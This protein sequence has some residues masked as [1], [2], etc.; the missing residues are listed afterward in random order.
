MKK[1]GIPVSAFKCMTSAEKSNCLSKVTR[2]NTRF[3]E[4]QLHYPDAVQ[5]MEKLAHRQKFTLFMAS[6]ALAGLFDLPEEI[7]L[8]D[9]SDV[10]LTRID[11]G[12]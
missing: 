12:F 1:I 8:E 11:G 6:A 3:D 7:V 2:I 4:L 10:R 5:Q 9:L